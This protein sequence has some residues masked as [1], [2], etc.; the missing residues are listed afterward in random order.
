MMEVPSLV[1][2]LLFCPD[3]EG[4]TEFELIVFPPN[5]NLVV[6]GTVIVDP[7]YTKLRLGISFTYNSKN[8]TK[9]Q[10]TLISNVNSTINNFNTN[11]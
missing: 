3:A 6:A 7:E 10:E 11:S 5:D 1:T 8:T 9:T 4:R 2:A